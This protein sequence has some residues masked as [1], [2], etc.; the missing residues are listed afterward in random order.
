[1]SRQELGPA[2]SISAMPVQ[3][4]RPPSSKTQSSTDTA[5]QL[6]FTNAWLD[7]ALIGG[8]SIIAFV[9][10]RIFLSGPAS[11]EVAQVAAVLSVFVNY[12]HFSATV[13]RLY[14]TPVNV[15]QFPLTAFAVPLLLMGGVA[16]SL[17]WP[18]LVGPYFVLLFVLWSP[19]HYSGQTIGVT[20]IYAR[21][22]G[23]KIAR[24]ERIALS[25][26]VFS[27]FIASLAQRTTKPNEIYGFTL[28]PIH[29]PDWLGLAVTVVM[30]SAAAMFLWLVVGWSLRSRRVLPPIILL[31]AVAQYVWFMVG[32]QFGAF[33]EFV[34]LFHSLQ[35]LYIAWAMQVGSRVGSD[36]VERSWAS[37][38]KIT[39]RWA[40]WNYFGGLALFIALPWIFFWVSLP[41][42]MVTGII[43]AAVNI[44]HFFVDG[45]IWK[46]RNRAT[47][48]PLMMNIADLAAP[49]H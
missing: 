30:W 31:P 8:L 14:E 7:A 4:L 43:V 48:S 19:Y 2:T 18:N 35:Y 16:A 12:P 3:G 22:A 37:I 29:Y 13:Y 34:P 20:M 39:T 5:A 28:P 33:Y 41:T 17:Y 27:T 10:A 40:L 49:A 25:G 24:W 23:F 46:L 9:V 1:M 38:W 45:V 21:R 26:F 32:I 47:A 36:A 11:R 15:R 6:Y 42:A 44:H